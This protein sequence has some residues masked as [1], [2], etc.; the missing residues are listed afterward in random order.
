M[1][2]KW[3]CLVLGGLV[4][5][6]AGLHASAAS[7]ADV[8]M[9]RSEEYGGTRF[10]FRLRGRGFSY[11]C[12][13]ILPKEACRLNVL[14]TWNGLRVFPVI[15]PPEPRPWV[16]YAPALRDRYPNRWHTWY[17]SRLLKAGVAVCGIDVGES[18]GNPKGRAA[19]SHFY[20]FVV[21]HWRFNCV[22]KACMLPECRGGLMVYNWA[23]ENP[24]RV[25]CI[26]AIYPVCE[27]TAT[28][29]FARIYGLASDEKLSLKAL[30]DHFK[31]HNPM[32]RLKPL[33]D[34]KIPIL[35]LHG[36]LD[37]VVPALQHSAALARRYL[38]LGGTITVM[39]RRGERHEPSAMLFECKEFARFL[40]RQAR[41]TRPSGRSWPITLPVRTDPKATLEKEKHKE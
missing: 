27:I 5:L 29:F 33:A 41:R 15:L 38:K 19:F 28:P 7:G 6:G 21:K 30:K 12:F 31:S 36:S 23:A 40:I 10:D 8:R 2:R 34:A 20:K 25:Q 24:G 9:T 14:L 32:D 39:I 22:P 11:R 35:H 1:S 13:V 37:K 17:F 4:A 18:W 26:G 16:W 3:R